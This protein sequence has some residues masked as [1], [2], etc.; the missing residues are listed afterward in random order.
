LKMKT[1][2]KQFQ[3]FEVIILLKCLAQSL[4]VLGGEF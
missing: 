4:T 3:K 1:W 2:S